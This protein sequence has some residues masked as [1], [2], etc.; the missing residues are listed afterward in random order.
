MVVELLVCASGSLNEIALSGS[1]MAMF[2]PQLVKLFGRIRRD[3]F[4]FKDL[5]HWGGLG[6]FK[7]PCH[8]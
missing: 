5:C 3:V 8:S 4:L 7:S 6:D 1:Y 2:G